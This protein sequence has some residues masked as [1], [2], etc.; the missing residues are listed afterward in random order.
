MSGFSKDYWDQKI[1]KWENSRYGFWSP[2][3]PLS[4]TVRNRTATAAKILN[5]HLRKNPASRLLELG[6]GSGVLLSQLKAKFSYYHGVDLSSEA[7][8]K[9]LEQFRGSDNVLF[10]S[11]NVLHLPDYQADVVVFL[12]LTDWLTPEEMQSLFSR[13][14][15]STL[16]FSFTTKK[17]TSLW[18]PYYYYRKWKDKKPGLHG[19]RARSY[20]KE[21]IEEWLNIR[22][23]TPYY[24]HSPIPLDP[25]L[26]VKAVR[27]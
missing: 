2:L 24:I 20:K 22:G 8:D 27:Q 16:L 11:S 12:G 6:C 19:Y 5:E 3:N 15:C 25:G 7:I 1:L 14:N 26:L 21:E 13:M 9:A 10:T 4:W 17:Q 18:N 23:Y